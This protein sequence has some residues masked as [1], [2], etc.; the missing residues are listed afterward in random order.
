MCIY[1]S[2]IIKIA[3][4]KIIIQSFGF[5]KKSGNRIN[6]FD[7]LLTATTIYKKL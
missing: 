7:L 4:K 3:N 1:E 2:K 6:Y 5:S